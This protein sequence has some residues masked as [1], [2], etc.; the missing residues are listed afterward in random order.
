MRKILLVTI[1]AAS[2]AYAQ[3]AVIA[4]AKGVWTMVKGNLVKSAEKMPEENYSFKPTPEVR[5]FGELVGH[6]ANASYF[7]CG[8]VNPEKAPAVNIEKTVTD[9]AG[10]VKA[11]SESVAY[12]DAAFA[13]LTDSN[14]VE[15]AKMMGRDMT[16][17][18]ILSFNNAHDMEH[19]G[20]MV[21]YMRMKGLVPPSSEK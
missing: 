17:L 7:F 14:A 11:L 9:K 13:A 10:L 12:C 21:T 19:Y 6:V 15:T 16:K 8:R 2:A 5:S 4:D 3:S 18:G 20:N 1:L